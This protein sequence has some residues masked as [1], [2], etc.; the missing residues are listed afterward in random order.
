MGLFVC[1]TIFLRKKVDS[2]FLYFI[3]EWYF[4]RSVVTEKYGLIPKDR[5]AIR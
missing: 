1:R 2:W 5:L 4:G 3:A